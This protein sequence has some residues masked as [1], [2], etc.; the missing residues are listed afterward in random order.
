LLSVRTAIGAVS[1]PDS[2]SAVRTCAV[3]GGAGVFAGGDVV[4][5]V[6]VVGVAVEVGVVVGVAVGVVVEVGV[7]G[8][9]AHGTV[10]SPMLGDP[11]VRGSLTV[12]PQNV[13][14][15]FACWLWIAGPAA[16]VKLL[17]RSALPPRS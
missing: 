9:P 4:V 8:P 11:A 2:A 7:V 15:L 16:P 13:V 12:L 3:A 10:G 1:V 6:V 5:G 17:F 14:S